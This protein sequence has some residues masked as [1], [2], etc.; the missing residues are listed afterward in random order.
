[1]KP[2]ELAIMLRVTERTIKR[3]EATGNLPASVNG[4]FRKKD[5][6]RWLKSRTYT[7]WPPKEEDG[8]RK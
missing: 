3:W 5:I 8:K 7:Q 4:D 1:M 2:S 6:D